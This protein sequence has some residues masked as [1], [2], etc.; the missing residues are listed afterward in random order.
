MAL[1]KHNPITPASRGAKTINYRA[2]L[3]AS[4]PNKKLTKGGK[5]RMGRATFGRITVRH[6]GGGSK[7]RYRD[8]DFKYDKRDVPAKIETIEYDPNRS[9]FIALALYADG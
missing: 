2:V 8:I 3:T 7:R 9:G 5:R 6:K 4:K 1:K